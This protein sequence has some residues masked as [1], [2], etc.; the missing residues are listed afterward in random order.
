MSA[1]RTRVCLRR[2]RPIRPR[3][4]G[5]CAASL[6]AAIAG[7]GGRTA[8][9]L[10]EVG[11]ARARGPGD[12]RG[13]IGPCECGTSVH[14]RSIALNRNGLP[15]A[16]VRDRCGD[17]PHHGVA[18]RQRERPGAGHDRPS[19]QGARVRRRHPPGPAARPARDR[20]PAAVLD[21]GRDR[22]GRTR[23]RARESRGIA[24][25]RRQRGRARAVD[26]QARRRARGAGTRAHR[27]RGLDARTTRPAPDRHCGRSSD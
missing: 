15:A 22:T 16:G 5:A 8:R 6:D 11:L 17:R 4:C 25:R 21:A 27:L 14:A 19:R 1:S 9:G 24:G 13:R 23:H 7:R 2:C 18:G 3:A 26:A 20:T 10:G 12:D